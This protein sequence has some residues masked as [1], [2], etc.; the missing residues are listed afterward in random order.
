M[1]WGIIYVPLFTTTRGVEGFGDW[2]TWIIAG[3]LTLILL[4]LDLRNSPRRKPP[5]NPWD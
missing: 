1:F 3:S 2:R 4:W 5:Q